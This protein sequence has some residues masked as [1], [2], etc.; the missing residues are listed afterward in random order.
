MRLNFLKFTTSLSLLCFQFFIQLCIQ[1]CIQIC[2]NGATALA[3]DDVIIAAPPCPPPGNWVYGITLDSVSNLSA[4]LTSLSTFSQKPTVRIVFDEFVPASNYA[5]AVSQIS[6]KAYIMGEIL[7]SFYMKQYS[8]DAY[9]ARTTEYIKAFANQVCMWEIGNEVNGNWLGSGVVQKIAAA[10]DIVK[11]A[12]LKTSM[13]TYYTKNCEDSN[14]DMLTW[15]Q[16]KIPSRMK[17][18][19]NW[20]TVSYY[21]DDCNNRIVSKTEWTSIF[22][23]LSTMFPNSSVLMGEVGTTKSTS[24]KESYMKRY[25]SMRLPTISKFL[26]GYFWWYGKQDL[27]PNTKYLWSVMNNLWKLPLEAGGDE[28]GDQDDDQNQNPAPPDDEQHP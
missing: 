1:F 18:G 6:K 3:K 22:Q 16:N 5:N 13:T 23:K 11:A 21:E 17:S 26:G 28:D 4:I 10:Y 7:D 8:L 20:V 14:G 15:L 9:K 25:Y 2:I 24:I 19:L 27:V 12:G